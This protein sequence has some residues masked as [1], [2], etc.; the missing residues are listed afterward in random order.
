MQIMPAKFSSW[1]LFLILC[2]IWGSSFILMKEGMKHLN[3]Y[4]VASIRILSGGMVLLP[5]AI[6]HIRQM[7]VS[8]TMLAMASGWL[9]TFIPAFLF[10]IAEQKISSSLASFLNALTPIFTIV[11]GLLFFQSKVAGSK[12]LG[13]FIGFTGMLLLFL[14]SSGNTF[15]NGAYAG[16]VVLATFLYGLNV[17]LVSGQLRHLPSFYI[18]SVACASLVPPAALT[19]WLAGW[20][21]HPTME[22]KGFAW[23]LTAS[24]VLG[25]MGTAVATILF[26]RLMKIA[27]GLF[28]SMVT[29]GIPFVALGWGLLAGEKVGALQ[30]AGLFIILLGVFQ[31]RK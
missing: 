20:S 5:F 27:G 4:E 6:K 26:Y 28:S 9:G 16:W 22:H 15:R 8:Q 14:A 13:V 25:V 23:S 18:T 11:C 21:T 3:P 29:Y 17:N 12:I 19:L 31:T 10:C 24:I 7:T 1:L 30:I 2:L